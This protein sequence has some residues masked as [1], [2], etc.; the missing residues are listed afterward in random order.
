MELNSVWSECRSYKAVVIGSNPIVPTTLLFGEIYY[1]RRELIGLIK[2]SKDD[3]MRLN[4][5]YG[6]PYGENG[7][8]HTVTKHSYFLCESR[9]N[10]N[11]YRKYE[12]SKR[13]R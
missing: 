1:E 2:I 11:I 4:K 13:N 5:K 3:A 6:I 7:I 9:Y 8:S 12:E 10:M